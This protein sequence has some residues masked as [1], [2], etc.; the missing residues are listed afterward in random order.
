M[1]IGFERTEI[2]VE[3]TQDPNDVQVVIALLT[4]N[5]ER[6]FSVIIETVDG[7]ARGDQFNSVLHTKVKC[8]S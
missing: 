1:T 7:T 4:G 8:C 5:T 6:E 2:I 3:E